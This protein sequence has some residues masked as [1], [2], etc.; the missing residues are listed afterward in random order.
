MLNG[1]ESLKDVEIAFYP[2]GLSNDFLKV[3]GEE[4]LSY[5]Q[6]IEELICGETIDVDYIQTSHGICVNTFSTG[7]DADMGPRTERYRSLYMLG[8]Q[9]PYTLSLLNSIFLYKPRELELDIDGVKVEGSFSELVFGNGFVMGGNLYFGDSEN[10]TDGIGNYCLARSDD[11]VSL[12]SKL[13]TLKK[14]DYEKLK[15]VT[16]CGNWKKLKL[17]S[18]DG[19][20]VAINQ[21]GEIVDGYS[22]WEAE[23]VPNGLHFVIPRGMIEHE[24]E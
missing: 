21:D 10:V 17:K 13:L 9:F 1:F 24:P 18:K 6:D 16:S 4:N 20:P 22:E 15:Q 23:I 14:R 19:M 3:F 2:C 7:I 5:F 11:G 8:K 12:V